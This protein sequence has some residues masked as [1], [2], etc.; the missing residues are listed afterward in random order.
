VNEP[1]VAQLLARDL[2]KQKETKTNTST[3][4]TTAQEGLRPTQGVGSNKKRLKPGDQG[5]LSNT[6]NGLRK[7][8]CSNKKRLKHGEGLPSRRG[9]RERLR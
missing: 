5:G 1:P 2:L 3:A 9:L 7:D 6:I 4:E 8:S